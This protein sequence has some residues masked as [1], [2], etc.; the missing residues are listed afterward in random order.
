[1]KKNNSK[2]FMLVETLIVTTFVCG[3]LIFLFIQF[4]NLSKNYENTYNYNSVEGL[5]SLNN[6]KKYIEN[7][8]QFILSIDLKDGYMDLTDCSL[9]T[10]TKYC[11][12][13][14]KL[15]KI[16]VIY[17]TENNFD[18][19]IFS[20]LNNKF[21]KFINMINSQ[22]NEKYRILVEFEDSTFATI[23]IGD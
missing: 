15:E 20:N 1:M 19:N 4:N 12:K 13:L 2:G 9:F 8:S 17:L 21:K 22:G 11:E 6:I 5:Y 3:V 14:F 23:R 7:D 18:K 10:D 16:K